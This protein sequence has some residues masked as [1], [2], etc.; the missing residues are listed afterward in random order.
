MQNFKVSQIVTTLI[1]SL[2]LAASAQASVVI[3]EVLY[4][5]P[6]TD[7]DDVFTELFGTPGTDLTGWSLLGINGGDGKVYQT[8]DLSG[9][10]IPEDGLFVI[11]TSAANSLLALQRDF[12][13]NI[14]WQNGPDAVQLIYGTDIMYGDAGS[15]NAGEGAFAADIS[16]TLSLSR[17]LFGTDT[18]NNAIDFTAGEPTPGSGP[19]VVPIP[20]AVWLFASGLGVMGAIR[21]RQHRRLHHSLIRHSGAAGSTG[22]TR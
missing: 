3:Q 1:L 16:G 10:V 9:L 8:I 17:D 5:G 6:G 4:D 19:A 11:A 22:P 20:A 18:N 12:I 14:D 7:A 13:A 2:W 21:R 15:Y